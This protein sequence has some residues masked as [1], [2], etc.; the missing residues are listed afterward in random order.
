MACEVLGYTGPWSLI[1]NVL[2]QV[3]FG[4]KDSSTEEDKR[5]DV[6]DMMEHH[7]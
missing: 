7:N 6:Q 1:P 2:S 4:T 5:A 3:H